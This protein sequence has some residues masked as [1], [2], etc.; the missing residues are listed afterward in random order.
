M[1]SRLSSFLAELKR[2][3]VY[4][5]GLA[6]VAVA[7]GVVGVCDAGIPEML[8]ARL[9]VPVG[10]LLLVGFPVALVLAWAYE[11]KPEQS[12]PVEPPAKEDL[13]TPGTQMP[14]RLPDS[15]KRKSIV[16][17]PFDNMSP[18]PGDAYF[19]DGLTEEIITTL[20]HIH[21]LRV[22]SRSS[23]MVLKGTQKDVRTIGQELDIEFVLEGSVRKAGDDLRITAQLIDAES[24]AHLWAE[25]YDGVFGDVF[26]IQEQVASSIAGALQLRLTPQEH[27]RIAE[28][29]IENVAAY[30]SY[31]RGRQEVLRGSV[32]ALDR[33]LRHQR[34]ALDLIGP[35]AH[36][37]AGIAFAY[38]QYVNLGLMQEDGI[39][40]AEEHLEKAL[41]LDPNLPEAHSLTGWITQAFRGQQQECV[42][43]FK[44]ALAINPNEPL[45][46]AG[47]AMSYIVTGKI[48]EAEAIV[49]RLTQVDPLEW[50]THWCQG[51]VYVYAGQYDLALEPWRGMYEREPEHPGG[52]VSY[53][54]LLAYR[55]E[56]PSALAVL[57]GAIAAKSPN[58][59]LKFARIL[60]HALL[61][62]AQG[63]EGEITPDL[64]KTALRDPWWCHWIATVYAILAA[65]PQAIRWAEQA[66][67]VG[68]INYP[69]LSERD[70]FL[71]RLRGEP[72]Y[73]ALLEKA[74][75]QWESF[76]V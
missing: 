29:P 14:A 55:G 39:A 75:H 42:R 74:K 45:A 56:I 49:D 50:L 28:R 69:M 73:E 67:S 15:E 13:R 76:E 43:T 30:E 31:L 19:A 62:N 68:F 61:G 60:K 40:L 71:T 47:L 51:A 44:R 20:S 21:S 25:K 33:A 18:D 3:K 41:A 72:R 12:R 24:D 48:P 9:Q 37:Y 57:E 11:L 26:A 65:V 16:V 7:A 4:H 6:Y 10:I 52:L 5:V 63:V 22:I 34:N 35:N 8:W 2:R 36:V 38:W 17:L 54:I 32:D 1:A 58:A 46:L 23:A 59:F 70:P 64:E 53:A 27:Q 66:V